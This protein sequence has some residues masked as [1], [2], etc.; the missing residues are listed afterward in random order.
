MSEEDKEEKEEREE[1][2]EREE[3]E[4]GRESIDEIF[5]LMNLIATYL[6]P[7][8]FRPSESMTAQ[9]EFLFA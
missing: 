6:S 3:L 7:I 1:D 2:E 4:G 5:K 8:Y 9:N